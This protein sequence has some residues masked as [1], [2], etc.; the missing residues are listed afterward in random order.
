MSPFW[1]YFPALYLLFVS[2]CSRLTIAFSS[3]TR[4][5]FSNSSQTFIS[6]GCFS[7]SKVGYCLANIAFLFV[8]NLIVTSTIA[9]G[10]KK[11]DYFY[12]M[13]MGTALLNPEITTVNALTNCCFSLSFLSSNCILLSLVSASA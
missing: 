13:V 7:L 6:C 9:F 2:A 8:N 10:N 3:L 1:S 11:V 4:Q 12:I 5:R